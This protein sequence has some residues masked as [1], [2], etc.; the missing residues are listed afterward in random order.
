MEALPLL[1]LPPPGYRNEECLCLHLA[2]T[3]RTSPIGAYLSLRLQRP[4]DYRHLQEVHP[5]LEDRQ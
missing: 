2:S 1:E 5:A 3:H 4:G